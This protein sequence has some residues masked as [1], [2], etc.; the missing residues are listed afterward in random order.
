M[1]LRSKASNRGFGPL[2]QVASAKQ[3][4]ASQGEPSKTSGQRQLYTTQI[5]PLLERGLDERAE[6]LLRLMVQSL[7]PI[8]EAVRDLARLLERQGVQEEAD[9]YFRSWLS[10]QPKTPSE[11]LAQAQKAEQLHLP[12]LARERY[13]ALLDRQPSQQE[14]LERASDLF[15]AEARFA[16]ALPLLERRLE[17]AQGA[18]SKPQAGSIPAE[19]LEQASRCAFELGQLAQAATWADQALEQTPDRPPLLAILARQQQHQGQEVNALALAD[20]AQELARGT[21]LW[22]LVNRLVAPIYLDQRQLE[23]AEPSLREALIAEPQRPD[24]HLQLAETLLLKQELLEGFKEYAW[25]PN[26]WGPGQQLRPSHGRPAQDPASQDLQEPL[27]LVAEGTLGDTLLFSRYG[28]WLKR[29]HG[30]DVRL[31]VQLP[32]LTLL[33][34]A[35]GDTLPV[36]P[37]NP[38]RPLPEG[39]P[40]SVLPLPSAPAVFGTCQEHP[41]LATPHLKADPHTD[42]H[43]RQLLAIPPGEHLIGVNWHGS[44]LQALTERHQSDIPL[45]LLAPLAELK[46]TQLV[47]LQKGIGSEQLESCPFRH[48]F[49]ASQDVVSRELRFEQTAALM[50]LCDWIVT[51]DSGPAHLAGCLGIPTIVLLAERSNWRWGHTGRQTPWYP[52]TIL[53]RQT[54]REGWQPLVA[55]ARQII[56]SQFQAL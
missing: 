7:A 35:L 3:R 40:G 27:V 46:N 13:L 49:I 34:Q 11:L 42:D 22:S 52:N 24:L 54:A 18:T 33:Q 8:P 43:W 55:Q 28:P 44:P 2:P 36:E 48:R 14:A 16:D 31:S 51:D 29:E 47:S 12:E 4:K 56:D 9:A 25:R 21:S 45:D 37:A 17:L 50:S 6:P 38:R 19:L 20:R 10:H 26:Q 39:R 5:L 53:L 30:L 32:L 23:R 41:A 15:M 1:A